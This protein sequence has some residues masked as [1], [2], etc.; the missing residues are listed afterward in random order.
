MRLPFQANDSFLKNTLNN[1]HFEHSV[2]SVV[3]IAKDSS[4][5]SE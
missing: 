3:L 1:C 4:L 5:C 2:K